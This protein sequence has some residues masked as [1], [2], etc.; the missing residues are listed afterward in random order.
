[1][2]FWRTRS[3]WRGLRKASASIAACSASHHAF[4]SASSLATFT[5]ASEST[6][7]GPS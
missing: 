7:P 1:M 4:F 5:G 2:A 6:L 3:W